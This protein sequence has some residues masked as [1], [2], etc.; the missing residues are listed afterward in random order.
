M[1]CLFKWILLYLWFYI[2]GF[3]HCHSTV[4]IILFNNKSLQP[5]VFSKCIFILLVTFVLIYAMQK[6]LLEDKCSVKRS[7]INGKGK[8]LLMF[9]QMLYNTLQTFIKKMTDNFS[10]IIQQK[11]NGYKGKDTK[12][13]LYHERAQLSCAIIFLDFS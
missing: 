3:L 10:L 9:V 13:M 1:P 8:V 12:V 6:M 2:S 7:L 4:S 5:S 11:G